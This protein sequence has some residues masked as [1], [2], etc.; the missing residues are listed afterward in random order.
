M[1][2]KQFAAML[3]V[4]FASAN[5]DVE[6]S[7]GVSSGSVIVVEDAP[8]LQGA[9]AGADRSGSVQ[10]E[11]TKTTTTIVDPAVDT[12]VAFEAETTTNTSSTAT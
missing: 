2:S 1:M 10:F 9:L 11:V 4:A 8:T 6:L 7:G 3:L 5:A 12:S